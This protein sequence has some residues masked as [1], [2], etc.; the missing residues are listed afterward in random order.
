MPDAAPPTRRFLPSARAANGLITIGFLALGY[1]LYMRY[2][3]IEQ[4]AIGIAC[5]GGLTTWQCQA[6][7]VTVALFEWNV[8][9]V[10]ALGFAV[11]TLIRPT[12]ALFGIALVFTA[13]GL[14]LHNDGLAGLAGAILLLSFARPV[15]E[16]A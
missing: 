13:L 3:V 1:A 9:G 15:I 2:M 10:L 4:H 16:E 11:L 8:F 7:K 6:R 5:D 14:V 12:T